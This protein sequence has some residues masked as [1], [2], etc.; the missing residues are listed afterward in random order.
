MALAAAFAKVSVRSLMVTRMQL[1]PADLVLKQ[2]L[3]SLLPSLWCQRAKLV[4]FDFFRF[5][6]VGTRRRT[7]EADC[8]C[9][10]QSHRL[11]DAT[12]QS[13]IRGSL[14]R[15]VLGKL[16]RLALRNRPPVTSSVKS[17]RRK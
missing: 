12:G 15:E 1:L 6:R 9:T 7:P 10:R 11:G 3:M 4:L 8:L 17:P 5:R 16:F 2:T 14:L 13:L